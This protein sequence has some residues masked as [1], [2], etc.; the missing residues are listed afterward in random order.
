MIVIKYAI[1]VQIYKM[2]IPV[3]INQINRVKIRTKKN[4]NEIPQVQTRIKFFERIK[5]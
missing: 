3:S 4:L 2:Y 1:K 5:S